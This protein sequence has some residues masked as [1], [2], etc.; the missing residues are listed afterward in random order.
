MNLWRW[1]AEAILQRFLWDTLSTTTS[2]T[3]PFQ[4]CRG[5]LHLLVRPLAAV[6]RIGGHQPLRV[7]ALLGPGKSRTNLPKLSKNLYSKLVV[8]PAAVNRFRTV[9]PSE[10]DPPA[11]IRSEVAC[12]IPTPRRH[13]WHLKAGT[14]K[15]GPFCLFERDSF[16]LMPN[17]EM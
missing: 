9:P 12:P 17:W 16:V 1:S 6:R 10:K 15:Q 7:I 4:G 8:V 5:P 11:G 13:H 14:K 2:S 3:S